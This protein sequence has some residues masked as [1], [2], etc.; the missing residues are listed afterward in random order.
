MSALPEPSCVL[1]RDFSAGKPTDVK[2]DDLTRFD[3]MAVNSQVRILSSKEQCDLFPYYGT[4]VLHFQQ[5]NFS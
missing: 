1:R 3:L 5:A 4:S 2:K